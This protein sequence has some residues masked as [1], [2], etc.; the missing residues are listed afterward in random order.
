MLNASPATFLAS[1]S[2][3]AATPSTTVIRELAKDVWIFSA[4]YSRSGVLPI[5]GRSTAIKLSTGGVWIFATHSLDAATRA[6]LA[7]LGDVRFI[8]SAD[9]DHHDFLSEYRDAY[10]DAK[11]IGVAALVDRRPDLKFEG[12]YGRE[13]AGTLYGYEDDIKAAFFGGHMKHDVAFFHSATKTMIEADLLFNLPPTESFSLTRGSG[14]V[15]GLS[16]IMTP[17]T[18]AHRTLVRALVKDRA[19]MKEPCTIVES[20]DFVRIVPC[21]G[22]VIETDAKNAWNALYKQYL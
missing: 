7:E 4:P 8:V 1:A 19:A 12:A 6:K 17:Y 11:L 16:K 20:W 14:N 5:G 9:R 22:D 21:H 2:I 3:M 13:P 15:P 18:W 10:P